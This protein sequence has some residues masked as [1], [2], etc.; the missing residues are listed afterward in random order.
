QINP[1]GFYLLSSFWL[2]RN[3]H[4]FYI[5]LA[6]CSRLLQAAHGNDIFYGV[7]IKTADSFFGLKQNSVS[8]RGL[9]LTVRVIYLPG[10]AE[11]QADSRPQIQTLRNLLYYF[12]VCFPAI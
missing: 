3:P 12:P 4:S 5:R 2:F 1:Q 6:G 11:G 9:R 7:I 10:R 8:Y